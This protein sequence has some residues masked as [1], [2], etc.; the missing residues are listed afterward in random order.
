M[1]KEAHN[2]GKDRQKV[3]PNDRNNLKVTSFM[4]FFTKLYI[5]ESQVISLKTQNNVEIFLYVR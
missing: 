1:F 2:S 5:M 3:Y 4:N